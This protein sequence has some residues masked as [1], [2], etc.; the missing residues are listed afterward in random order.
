MN[1]IDFA[2]RKM[3]RMLKPQANSFAQTAPCPQTLVD[4]F[5]GEWITSFPAPH[6]GVTAGALPTFE[7][8]RIKWAVE[9]FGGVKDKRIL[10]LGP[11]E[12]GHSYILSQ[13]G[14]KHVL[15][16]EANSTAYLKC[17]LVRELFKLDRIDFQ[18]GDFVQYLDQ[19]PPGEK[20]DAI[21]AS[22]VLYHM[23]DPIGLLEK[24]AK[25]ADRVYLWT[26]FFNHDIIYKHA[27]LRRPF[28]SHTVCDYKGFKFTENRHEYTHG[29]RLGRFLGGNRAYS[30]WLNR[31][32]IF[33]ALERFGLSQ[34]DIQFED[35]AHPHGPCLSLV[36]SRKAN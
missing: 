20:F 23:V 1:P 35:L 15:A 11:M 33:G 21:L 25:A 13:A 34:I 28:R 9:R 8:P 12:G 31:E 29:R 27:H 2:K 10:E 36:A 30:V 4:I 7:D 14:V 16:I 18:Y 5:K 6:D 26:H 22:G 17:L 3:L 24:I 32:D 19:M